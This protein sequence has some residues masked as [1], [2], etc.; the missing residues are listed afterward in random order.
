MSSLCSNSFVCFGNSYLQEKRYKEAVTY[1][2]QAKVIE[3]QLNS[4]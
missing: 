3:K 1:Y 2:E 4:T